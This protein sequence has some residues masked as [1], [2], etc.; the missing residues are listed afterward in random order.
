MLRTIRRG[1]ALGATTL[2]L[3]VPFAHPAAA[4]EPVNQA[5][6][7]HDFS[8][9]AQGGS[10]FGAFLAG[11]ASTTDGVGTEVQFHLAGQVPDTTIPNTCND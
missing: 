6:L 1:I 4:A 10:S 3:V 7:G 9:Y 8:G 5:C 11:L 2:T